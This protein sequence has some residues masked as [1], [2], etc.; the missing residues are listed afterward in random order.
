MTINAL[1]SAPRPATS[2]LNG[3]GPRPRILAPGDDG[4]ERDDDG[5]QPDPA[6]D[7]ECLPARRADVAPSGARRRQARHGAAVP[8][9]KNMKTAS[10]TAPTATIRR[11]ALNEIGLVLIAAL[12]RRPRRRGRGR[13]ERAAFV[14]C[15]EPSAEEDRERA[16]EREPRTGAHGRRMIGALEHAHE[17]G[18]RRDE[19]EQD[20]PDGRGDGNGR[21]ALCNVATNRPRRS[22]SRRAAA[23]RQGRTY[24]TPCAPLRG[25]HKRHEQRDDHAARR[26]PARAARRRAP[27]AGSSAIALLPFG[28]LPLAACSVLRSRKAIVIGPT[29]PGTG[30]I[31]EAICAAATKSTS[32]TSPSCA[33]PRREAVHADVDHD[34]ARLDSRPAPISRGR[35]TAAI[36][37]S[38]RAQTSARSRVREWHVVTVAFSASSSCAI[39][40]PNR[41]E[42]PTTTASAP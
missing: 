10:A 12:R 4:A 37:T 32:P 30:V 31:A 18:D 3:S 41:F 38:A 25:F 26:R 20:R 23:R 19:A 33:A 16:G 1:A 15:R 17:R 7:R 14:V 29:P 42:R 40:L 35:P 24:Q 34:R 9:E 6:A 28:R 11:A 27:C 39:G 36:S 22:P 21:A 8:I 13:I 2:A 5:Q